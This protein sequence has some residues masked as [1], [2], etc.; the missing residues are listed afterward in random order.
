MATAVELIEECFRGLSAGRIVNHPRRRIVLKNRA[1]LHYMAAGDNQR[2]FIATKNYVTRPG[3]GAEFAVL[4]FDAEHAKLLATIEANALGQIRTGAASGVAAGYMSR[5]DAKSV[6]LVGTGFQAETQLEALAAVRRLEQVKVFSRTE[7]KRREFA[8]KMSARLGLEIEAAASAEAA[9]RG[10]DIVITI[11]SAREPVVFGEWLEPGCHVNAAGSNHLR[12]REID[13]EVV[14]R[15]T[16]VAADSVEQAM[17]EAGDLAGAVE[18]G[19][20]DWKQVLE[21]SEIAAGKASGRTSPDQ[22]TLFESQGLAAEDLAAAIY[23]YEQSAR[24]D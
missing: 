6:G 18:E 12:R 21:F 9:V 7:E 15:A 19:V 23:V 5:P 10:S 17:L 11:T 4:L 22:I 14:R 8:K 2:N 16:V 13:A 20:F 24:S 3:V 1:V